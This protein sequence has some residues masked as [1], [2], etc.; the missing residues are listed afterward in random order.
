MSVYQQNFGAQRYPQG[1]GD[2]KRRDR[3]VERQLK[4]KCRLGFI[5]DTLNESYNPGKL[6]NIQSHHGATDFYI[7]RSVGVR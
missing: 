4:G 5:S 6:N 3:K 1:G 2:N 7:Y